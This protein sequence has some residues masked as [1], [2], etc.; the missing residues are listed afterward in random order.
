MVLILLTEL[1]SNTATAAAFLPVMGAVAVGAA[2]DPVLMSLTVAMA[3]TCAFMLPVATPS[4]AVAYATGEFDMRDM[5]RGGV[6]LNVAGIAI[7]VGML[8][9]VAP[10][11]F[12]VAP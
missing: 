5:V 12:G 2:L 10:M 8:Y 6:W 9:V 3:V 1:T 11:V 4:N 7:T